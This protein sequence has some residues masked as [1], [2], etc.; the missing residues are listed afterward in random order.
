VNTLF[1]TRHVYTFVCVSY[2]GLYVPVQV[3]ICK[4]FDPVVL[5][6]NVVISPMAPA[7]VKRIFGK[8]STLSQS[9]IDMYWSRVE[10]LVD[11]DDA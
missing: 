3:M 8:Q 1:T 5:R 11:G 6:G 9:V 10:N 4:M 2:I 7:P